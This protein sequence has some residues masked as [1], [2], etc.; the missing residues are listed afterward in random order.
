MQID[1]H[2]PRQ[3]Q[4]ET[5]VV[6]MVSQRRRRWDTIET[7]FGKCVVLLVDISDKTWRDAEDKPE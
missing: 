3:H 2:D 1:Y 6:L 7:T 4:D 5:H